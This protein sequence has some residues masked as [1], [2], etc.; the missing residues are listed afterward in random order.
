MPVIL[1]NVSFTNVRSLNVI[2]DGLIHEVNRTLKVLCYSSSK[3]YDDRLYNTYYQ[4]K[5]LQN[6]LGFITS[7]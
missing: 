4:T 5:Y 6:K 3:G 1:Y 2:I 7:E